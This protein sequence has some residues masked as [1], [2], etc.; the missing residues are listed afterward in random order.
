M[1]LFIIFL[2]VFNFYIPSVGP[3]LYIATLL[4]ILYSFLSIKKLFRNRMLINKA[5]GRY[6][7]AFVTPMLLIIA[8]VSVRA[9]A[10]GGVDTSYVELMFK[11][12]IFCFFTILIPI[13]IYVRHSGSYSEGLYAF[14]KYLYVIAALQ[15]VIIIA[16][17]LAPEFAEVVRMLQNNDSNNSSLVAAGLRG[18]ALSSMQ[19][20]GLSCFYC[21]ILIFLANDF[22]RN[23]TSVAVT[24][25]LVILFSFSAIFVSRTSML[26]VVIFILYI[27]NPFASFNK[28][29]SIRLLV[30]F[31]MAIFISILIALL[32]VPEKILMISEKVLPWAF[33]FIYRYQ[34][35]GELSTASTDE[36]GRMYFPLNEL[37]LIFGDGKYTG[38][39]AASYYMNTDAGYMRT[40]LYG[41]LGLIVAMFCVW[42]YWMK[43]ICFNE[44]NRFLLIALVILSFVLQYK[45]EFILT[46]YIVIIVFS[47][48]LLFSL[49]QRNAVFKEK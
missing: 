33:E 8:I 19:Y 9:I 5:V 21:V 10:T 34:Q 29:R 24:T 35:G 32:V 37:T 36:L 11:S 14:N 22:V 44:N 18:V 7:L 6:F 4:S 48:Q 23:K 45:G 49:L 3:T 12:L 28:K 31:G 17:V 15:S 27:L 43:S 39:T 30:L 25:V 20:Y 46:N 1:L 16:A 47:M 42:I 2:A 26:G 41:G 38:I 40:I 13:N